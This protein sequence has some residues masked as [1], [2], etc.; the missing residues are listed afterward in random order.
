MEVGVSDLIFKYDLFVKAPTYACADAFEPS[1]VVYAT[2]S[3]YS[4]E[5]VQTLVGCL[6]M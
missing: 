1:R 6:N 3:T 4:R 5:L 2:I